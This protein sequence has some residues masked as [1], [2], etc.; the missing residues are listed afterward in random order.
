MDIPYPSDQ[1]MNIMLKVC[2]TLEFVYWALV[3][4]PQAHFKVLV[5][6]T[7]SVFKD[8]NTNFAPTQLNW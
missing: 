7:A 5:K 8:L 4:L 6:S 1:N 2:Q 3:E